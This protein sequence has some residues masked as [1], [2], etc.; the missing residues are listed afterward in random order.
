MAVAYGFLTLQHLFTERV[1]DRLIPVVDQAIADSVA[2]HNRQIDALRSLFVQPTEAYT[3]RYQQ[4]S[5][6]RLQPLDERGRARP[7]LPAGYYDVAFPIKEAG[8]AWGNTFKAGELMTVGDVARMT[9]MMTNADVVWMRDNILAALFAATTYTFAD[10]AY[11]SLTIQPI[12]NGDTV[13]YLRNGSLT[14]AVDTHQMGQAAEIL[15]ASDPFPTIFTELTEHPGNTGDVI[16]LIASDLVAATKAL[17]GFHAAADPNIQSGIS[18]DRLVGTFGTA[19]PG[20]LLGYHD[21]GVWIAEWSSLPNHYI[22]ATTTGGD[23]PL[24]MREY[25]ADSLK[26]FILIPD[27]RNDHPYYERQ[28]VRYAGFGAFNRVGAIVM[29]IADATYDVPTG[30]TQPIA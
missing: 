19:V 16:A 10:D 3:S 24:A 27:P 2:E 15:D 22:V 26:G 8:T 25:P 12:A 30:Y 11:G 9:A 17:T 1:A 28:Y 5:A 20:T 7:V 6:N 29:E 14:S 13:T 23:R 21:S 4:I 18:S